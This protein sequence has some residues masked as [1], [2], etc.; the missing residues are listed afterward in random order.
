VELPGYVDSLRLYE[1]A[2]KGGITIA[3]GPIFSVRK[4]YRNYIRLNAA[5]WS[6]KIE[7]ALATLGTL[8]ESMSQ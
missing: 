6:E 4:G 5:F 7:K 2:L 1:R 3:P 8:A